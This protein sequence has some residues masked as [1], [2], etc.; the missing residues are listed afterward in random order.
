MSVE[1]YVNSWEA[2]SLSSILFASIYHWVLTSQLETFLGIKEP[3]ALFK[4]CSLSKD[5]ALKRFRFRLLFRLQLFNI[6][7]W[8]FQLQE[9]TS[10]FSCLVH[11]FKAWLIRALDFLLRGAWWHLVYV[12]FNYGW[13][14]HQYVATILLYFYYS[15]WVYL[16]K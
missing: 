16:K 8:T 13:R 11:K 5:E 3:L 6:L 14:L 15:N 9:C 10:V 7:F 2:T 4:Q 1:S 12:W